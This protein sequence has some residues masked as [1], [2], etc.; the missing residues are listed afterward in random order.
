MNKTFDE[1]LS[2]FQKKYISYDDYLKILQNTRNLIDDLKYIQSHFERTKKS[3]YN[4]KVIPSLNGLIMDYFF[5]EIFNYTLNHY[6]LN[7]SEIQRTL[8]IYEIT[9]KLMNKINMWDEKRKEEDLI[10]VIKWSEV[11]KWFTEEE[12]RKHISSFCGCSQLC[13]Q[14]ATAWDTVQ[15]KIDLEKEHGKT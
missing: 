3:P 8:I 9:Y 2:E 11:V 6:C 1:K 12:L 7:E 15:L 13:N 5:S 4:I 14:I 10:E